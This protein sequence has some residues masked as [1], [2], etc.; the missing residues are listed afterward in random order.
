MGFY[1]S[2][3]LVFG[4][5]ALATTFAIWTLTANRLVKRKLKLSLLLLGG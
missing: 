4:I 2:W 3:H 5:A 1:H